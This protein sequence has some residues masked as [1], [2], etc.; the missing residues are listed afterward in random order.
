MLSEE[1]PQWTG[2]MQKEF[3]TLAN[4]K[5]FNILNLVWSRKVDPDGKTISKAHSN[6]QGIH[7]ATFRPPLN[8]HSEKNFYRKK[9]S[10][11]R[12]RQ[13]TA[14]VYLSDLV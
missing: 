12:L 10:S 8:L 9:D 2:A 5:I 6:C 13:S 14:K 11:K 4:M 3:D 7:H 1:K